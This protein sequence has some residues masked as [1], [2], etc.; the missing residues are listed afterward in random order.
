M[1]ILS[2]NFNMNVIKEDKIL[3]K[4]TSGGMI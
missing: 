3:L 2:E 4:N 1:K